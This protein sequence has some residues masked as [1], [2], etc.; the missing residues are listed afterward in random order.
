MIPPPPVRAPMP[1]AAPTVI[2]VSRAT[3]IAQL[4]GDYDR[5]R[6]QP[7]ANRTESRYKLVSTDL[8]VPFH[9]KGRTYLLFGDTF[10]PPKGDAISACQSAEHF[11]LSG[12]PVS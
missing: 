5:E 1:P 10:G 7:T 6:Q 8:G 3:K 2:V 9:H 12:R 4:V 11:R